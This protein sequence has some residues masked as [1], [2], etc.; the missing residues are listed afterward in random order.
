MGGIGHTW[1]PGLARGEAANQRGDG[2][3][4]VDEIESLAAE[5]D[6]LRAETGIAELRFYQLANPDL[7]DTIG[8]N[9]LCSE[10]GDEDRQIE[11]LCDRANRL[12]NALRPRI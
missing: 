5:Q 1:H 6:A 8:V 3:M 4:N 10:I 9:G 12:V 2:R 11:W 7:K